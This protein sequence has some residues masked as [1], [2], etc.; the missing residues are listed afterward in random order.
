MCEEASF[1][2]LYIY[3]ASLEGTA[4]PTWQLVAAALT[5]LPSFH[6][7]QLI[8]FVKHAKNKIYVFFSMF[9]G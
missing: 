6:R 4:T 9:D 2:A 8:C 7:S 1:I 5:S 3:K